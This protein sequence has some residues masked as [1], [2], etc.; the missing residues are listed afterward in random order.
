MS[1][2]AK[3]GIPEYWIVNLIARQLEVYR[4]PS[5]DATQLYGFGYA[6][7]TICT[8]AERVAPLAI[9]EAAITVADLLP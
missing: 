3:A 8:A 6:E 5:V 1:L 4:R 7:V 2:Y 9:P